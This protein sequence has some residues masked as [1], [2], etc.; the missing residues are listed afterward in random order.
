[1]VSVKDLQQSVLTSFPVTLTSV[2]LDDEPSI[3]R[4]AQKT[5]YDCNADN[6][7]IVTDTTDA[8]VTKLEVNDD[9]NIAFVV[10]GTDPGV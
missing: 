7:V 9:C 3:V 2:T 10:A 6:P 4:R 1:M 5:E 8:P